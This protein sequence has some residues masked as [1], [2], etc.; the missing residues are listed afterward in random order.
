MHE[1]V[2][3][4]DEK[5]TNMLLEEQEDK[6]YNRRRQISWNSLFQ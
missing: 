3:K 2:A 1:A 5:N 4:I 6:S